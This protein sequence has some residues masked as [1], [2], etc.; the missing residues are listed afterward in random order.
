[1]T[2]LETARGVSRLV[3]LTRRHAFKVPRVASWRQF[4]W[5]LLANLQEAEYGRCGW[6]ELCPVL[7]A[8]PLGLCV[9]MPRARVCTEADAPSEDEYRRLTSDADR[10]VPAEWKPSS[11]GRLP[12]GRLV[13]VDYGT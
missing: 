3:V 5:G 8:A 10:P 11:W 7:W 1:M 13:A 9:V 2:A 12:D 6:P 4:L